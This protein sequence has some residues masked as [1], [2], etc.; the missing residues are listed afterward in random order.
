MNTETQEI[1]QKG[2]QL[3]E[4][5]YRRKGYEILEKNWRYNHLEIDLI[6][7]NEKEIV[8]CEVKT[9][10]N[11]DFGEPET[12]VTPSK[13][14]NIIRAANIYVKLNR[15]DK[16]ARFDIISITLN[17]EHTNINHLPDAFQP[18]W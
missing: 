3:A 11:I 12:F 14:Q 16:D 18:R 15:I 4:D 1:G 9:R 17:G 6:A 8:F 7:A 13:Q 5:F 2:E 10:S